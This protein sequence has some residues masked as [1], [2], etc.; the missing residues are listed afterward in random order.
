MS[1]FCSTLEK[2]NKDWKEY[3]LKSKYT[4]DYEQKQIYLQQHKEAEEN[5]MKRKEE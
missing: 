1:E 3:L 2:C 4:Y 5:E